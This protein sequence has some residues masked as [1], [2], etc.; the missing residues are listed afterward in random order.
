MR[1]FTELIYADLS[2]EITGVLF[3]VQNDLGRFCN[4]KQYGDRI[5]EE[6]NARN[7]NY[8]RELVLPPSFEGEATGRNKIDFLV[9]DKIILELKAKRII[10]K[11]DY[12]QVIR[13]L[14]AFDKKLGLLVNFRDKYLKPRRVL[15][16]ESQDISN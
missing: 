12:Y 9:E 6:F 1:N 11:E 10:S 13:Y 3:K 8:A 14:R 15:N 5:A 4:E 7:I 16:S 2:Y